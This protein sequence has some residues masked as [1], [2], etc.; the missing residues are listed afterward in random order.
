MIARDEVKKIQL[1][2]CD[3]TL[4]NFSMDFYKKKFRA[5]L[6][7]LKNKTL[8]ISHYFENF[9]ILLFVKITHMV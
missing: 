3:Y 8:K 5:G 6:L 1:N 2:F 4:K 7:K 9:L